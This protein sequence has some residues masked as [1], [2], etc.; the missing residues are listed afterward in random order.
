MSEMLDLELCVKG[1]VLGEQQHID[2]RKLGAMA[3]L[4]LRVIALGKRRFLLRSG[5]HRCLLK[6]RVAYGLN[7]PLRPP[8]KWP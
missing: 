2:S 6:R 8:P 1:D 5:L 7:G 3:R 4:S